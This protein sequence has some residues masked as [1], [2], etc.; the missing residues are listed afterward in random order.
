MQKQRQLFLFVVVVDH[1]VDYRDSQV[2]D[3][4]V[5]DIQVVV[6]HKVVEDKVVVDK[7]ADRVVVGKVV[8]ALVVDHKIVVVVVVEEEEGVFLGLDMEE[9]ENLL[10]VLKIVAV[11]KVKDCSRYQ[12]FLINPN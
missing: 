6:D 4:M 11:G 10:V 1:K 12:P 3:R 5:V 2:V 7:V 8:V 9:V